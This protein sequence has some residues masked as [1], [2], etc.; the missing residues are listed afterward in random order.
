MLPVLHAVLR[1]TL[2]L[3]ILLLS[4]CASQKAAPRPDSLPAAARKHLE[5]GYRLAQQQQPAAALH[6]FE[7]A[8]KLAPR[9]PPLLL[10]IGLAHSQLQHHG[11]AAAWL[12]AWLATGVSSPQQAAIELQYAREH[13]AALARTNAALQRALQRLF[14]LMQDDPRPDLEHLVTPMARDMAGAGDIYGAL[15]LLAETG[16]LL[17]AGARRAPWLPA[18]RDRAWEAYARSLV[19]TRQAVLAEQARN[20]IQ[21]RAV[22]DRFWRQLVDD[23]TSAFAQLPGNLHRALAGNVEG[24]LEWIVPLALQYETPAAPHQRRRQHLRRHPER[25]A[26]PALPERTLQLAEAMTAAEPRPPA[27][28]PGAPDEHSGNGTQADMTAVDVGRLAGHAS[29]L[30]TLL[31]F[32][33]VTA[34]ER[35]MTPP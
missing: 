1:C 2:A 18:A 5:Q 34:L 12:N 32:I 3:T 20:N 10:N 23:P 14:R 17:S 26:R 21:N 27:A 6:H 8:R 28:W 30:N 13:A 24:G 11:A 33:Q 31:F 7:A 19:Y 16:R 29:A 9:H 25:Y 4:A 15:Q 22:R 35:H